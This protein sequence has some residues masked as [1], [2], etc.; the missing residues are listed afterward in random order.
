M[1]TLTFVLLTAAV[2][3]AAGSPVGA[4]AAGAPIGPKQAF[5]GLVNGAGANAVIEMA[6]FGPT[7]P[8]QMGHPLAGQSLEV[9][10]SAAVAHGGFTGR[11]HEIA[12]YLAFPASAT[13]TGVAKAAIFGSYGTAAEIPTSVE[14][15]CWGSGQAEFTPVMGGRTAR[16]ASVSVSFAGQP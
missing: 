5:S 12:G 11:A 3:L 16:S 14:L 9:L 13:A 15:P 6:C 1:R 4:Q 7:R 2:G 10:R 8:G